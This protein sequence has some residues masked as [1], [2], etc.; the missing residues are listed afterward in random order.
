MKYS[1]LDLVY[2]KEDKSV[3]DA[4]QELAVMAKKAEA[5][6]FSRYWLAEHHNMDGVASVATSIL[7]GYVASQTQKMRVG[8]GG[9]MLPN[10]SS[11]IISEQFGTL[12]QLYGERIDLGLGR[13]PGTDGLTAQYLNENFIKNVHNFPQNI[14]L[15]QR[16]FSEDNQHSKVRANIAEGKNVPIY[17]LGSSTD[18][19]VLA[20]SKGL[21]YAFASHFVPQQMEAAFGIYD[22]QFQE[23]ESGQKP[24][25]I[26]CVNVIIGETDEEAQLLS[27][28]FYKMFLGIIRNERSKMKAPDPDFLEGWTANESAI[29]SQMTACSFIGSSSTVAQKIA[30]F[31]DRFAIDEL[32]ISSPIY[33]LDKRLQS[34]EQFVSIFDK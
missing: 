12:A 23:N 29:I 31:V 28:S 24:Y 19:A 25:K 11:L 4:M 26:A 32:M 33:D 16:F 7:I 1:F 18:S 6:N 20:A 14:E 3:S 21:P 10:H 22:R 5:L 9:I 13:A 8:S 15:I 2:V 30:N 27:S 34:M 17:I